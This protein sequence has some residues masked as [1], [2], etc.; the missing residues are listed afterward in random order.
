MN[1]LD[2]MDKALLRELQRDGRVTNQDLAQCV[3][4]SPAACLERVKRLREKGVIRRYM[5][6]IDPGA[7]DLALLIFVEV[8]LHSTV[9]S[10][11]DEFKA[12]VRNTPEI[13]EC[14]LVAG[15]F[16]YL[17]K[18][19]VRDMNAYRAFLGE[20]LSALPGVR[21]TRTYAVLEEV[22]STT[23]LPI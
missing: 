12:I 17:I 5:I 19:R 18:A 11:L 9:E 8:S 1:N 23:A 4:L 21:E 10:A 16:D 13:L 22:K 15:G 20:R 7:V 3:G 2:A 6:D 14:H